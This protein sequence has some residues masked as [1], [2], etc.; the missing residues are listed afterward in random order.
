MKELREKTIKELRKVKENLKNNY[1]EK[2]YC[3]MIN[4]M[5]DY[6]NESQDNLYLYDNAMEYYNFIDNEIL[7]QYIERE[8]KEYGVERVRYIL[9][10]TI[11]SEVYILDAYGNLENVNDGMFEDCID[12][13]IETLEKAI[14]E[15][16]ESEEN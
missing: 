8:L 5:I 12:Q 16:E 11:N 7:E 15:D 13:A 4:A 9:G 10:D 14:V 2:N 3:D 1:D 6:D